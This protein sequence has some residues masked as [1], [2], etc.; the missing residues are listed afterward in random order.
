MESRV[1]REW[2]DG[3]VV[4]RMTRADADTVIS[5]Y[6][7]ICATSVDLQVGVAN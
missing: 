6:S 2:A 4:R 5:W 3:F 7:A 1:Y